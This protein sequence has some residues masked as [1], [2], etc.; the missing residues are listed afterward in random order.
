[1]AD[2]TLDA[3][4]LAELVSEGEVTPAELVE[5]AISRI[6]ALNP[7][8]NAVICPLYEAARERA[9]SAELPEG[10]FRGVPFLTK[11]LE[12]ATAGDPH[13]MGCAALKEIDHRSP[14][15]DEVAAAFARA[16]LVNLGRT[17]CPELGSTI[18]TEPEAYGPTLNP[19]DTGHST[20]GSSG[21]SAAAVAAGMVPMAHA[22]DGGGS[23]RIPASECGLVGLKPTRGRVS[24]G[25]MVGEAWAGMAI[26]GVVTRSVRDT[27]AALD[28]ISTPAVGD[29]YWAPPPERPF[30]AEVGADPGSLRIGLAPEISSVEVHPEC[31]TAVLEAGR[32][33]ESLGHH[34]EIA[35]PAALDEPGYNDTFVTLVAVGTAHS[36]AHIEEIL[37]REVGPGDLERMNLRLAEI[38]RGITGPDYMAAVD[39]M[40]AYGRRMAGWWQPENGSPGF[41]VLVTPTLAGPPP[42]IGWLMDP[43]EGGRRLGQLMGFTAQ[44]NMT[45]QPAVS[46][47]L[48]WTPGGLPVGVQ[49]VGPYAGEAG[50]I[51]LA[52]QIEAAAPW[53]DRLP[54]I[55]AG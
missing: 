15:T 35:Q 11:D 44:F 51:R 4:A 29:P 18:T 16:G 41:D 2:P 25:P 26:D 43:K 37:G 7:T 27:A 48:H 8:L 17:N 24:H 23:I 53:S 31:R 14:H 46:L 54:P 50:L 30:T 40:H 32:L 9:L 33:L 45:G 1:M 49:F 38:G 28:A 5:D 55:F 20:G 52:S 6:E 22:N 12:A 36:V 42:P 39:A 3:T 10:P 13:H 19:W 34:V 47:P 21:G